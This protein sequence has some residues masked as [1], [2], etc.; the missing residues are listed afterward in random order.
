MNRF[1]LNE[2]ESDVKAQYTARRAKELNS[3]VAGHDLSIKNDKIKQ[4]SVSHSK[5]RR[6]K[7][8]LA[9]YKTAKADEQ[10]ISKGK[11]ENKYYSLEPNTKEIE[12]HKANRDSKIFNTG[13]SNDRKRAR[14]NS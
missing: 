4:G 1:F 13:N 7:D 2:H 9:Q 14:K 3:N 11:M 6:L 5:D 8:T 10:S 12:R